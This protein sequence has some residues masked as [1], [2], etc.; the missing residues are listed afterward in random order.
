MKCLFGQKNNDFL[1][2]EKSM[3]CPSVR[4][5]PHAADTHPWPTCESRFAR[6]LFGRQHKPGLSRPSRANRPNFTAQHRRHRTAPSTARRYR[7]AA[8]H[9]PTPPAAARNQARAYLNSCHEPT[10]AP[11]STQAASSLDLWCTLKK[12]AKDGK[13]GSC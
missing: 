1:C 3:F 13:W 10:D 5:T 8:P 6:S 11:S 9:R 7:H 12:S 4:R 2:P